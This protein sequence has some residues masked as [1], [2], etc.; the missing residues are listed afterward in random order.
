MLSRDDTLLVLVDVQGKL[1]QLMHDRDALFEYLQR[2][3]RGVRVLGLPVIWLEQN[4][5][6]LGPT[7]PELAALLPDLTPI[8]KLCFS[9]CRSPE[10][11]RALRATGRR[12]VLVC[13]IE[14]H[15]CV[16]Q[17][18]VDLLAL[19]YEVQVVTDAVSSRAAANRQI[20]LERVRVAGAA[21]TSAEMCLFELQRVAEG[22][23]FKELLKIVR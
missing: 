20:G 3:V 10:F 19:G 7:L 22:P 8:A 6:G 16:Y 4:P 18:T 14:A 1:A 11:M 13:G 15:V 2:L 9:C 12:Q 21:L 17:T 23:V 5:R